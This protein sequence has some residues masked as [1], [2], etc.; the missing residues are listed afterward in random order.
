LC[1]DYVDAT[2]RKKREHVVFEA[3]GMVPPAAAPRSQAAARP[4]RLTVQ[5]A[6][7]DKEKV[8]EESLS[9]FLGLSEDSDK[10]EQQQQPQETTSPRLGRASG[11][12]S[13]RLSMMK[14]LAPTSLTEELWSM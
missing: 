9:S 1:S 12:V 14:Q 5:P 4:P 6:Q 11:R 7:E 3:V 10:Q 2:T 13:P 8:P